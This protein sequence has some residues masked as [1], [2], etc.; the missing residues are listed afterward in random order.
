VCY[1][2]MNRKTEAERIF[3]SIVQ[4]FEDD[5]YAEKAEDRIKS[6]Q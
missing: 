5:D 4:N 1:L 3:Q 6:M 2:K